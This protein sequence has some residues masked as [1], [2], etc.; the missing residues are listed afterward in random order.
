[1]GVS[2][3]PSLP[4]STLRDMSSVEESVCEEERRGDRIRTFIV[5][6]GSRFTLLPFTFSGR[7]AGL[8]DSSGG[9]GGFARILRGGGG[10][11][12]F[13]WSA[14]SGVGLGDLAELLEVLLDG[15]GSAGGGFVGELR[16]C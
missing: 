2:L 16:K 9:S 5:R 10:S 3:S 4:I 6:I 13:V 12:R 11:G 1:M 15:A 7:L 14:G 8:L